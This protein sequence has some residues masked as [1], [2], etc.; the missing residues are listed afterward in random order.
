VVPLVLNIFDNSYSIQSEIEA[1]TSAIISYDLDIK[2][3]YWQAVTSVKE[4]NTDFG[5]TIS[6][7]NPYK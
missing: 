6:K 2:F 1:D 5:G 7:I 3:P 4:S